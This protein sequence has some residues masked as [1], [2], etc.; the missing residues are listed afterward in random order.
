MK[1][2]LLTLLLS[3]PAHA[4]FHEEDFGSAQCQAK[5]LK[6]TTDALVKEFPEQ[7]SQAAYFA[8]VTFNYGM[9]GTPR[10]VFFGPKLNE[11]SKRCLV[12][13]YTKLGN[14]SKDSCPDY[15]YTH[16]DSNC[17]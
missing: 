13:V 1:Y 17:R 5:L 4:D 14:G 15:I 3:M 8:E 12:Q 9:K 2:L 11:S 10:T 7:A 16:I 6:I